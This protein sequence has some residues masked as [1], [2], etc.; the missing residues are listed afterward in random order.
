MSYLYFHKLYSEFPGLPELLTQEDMW[1]FEQELFH[2][3]AG[4][5]SRKYQLYSQEVHR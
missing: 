2:Q 5:I 1:I 3:A 4:Y